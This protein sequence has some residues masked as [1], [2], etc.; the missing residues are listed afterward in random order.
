MRQVVE[1][2]HNPVRI[3]FKKRKVIL[4]SLDDLFQADLINMTEYFK[5]NR[6]FKYILMVINC[7]S[8]Y[9]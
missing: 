1:E 2:V 7:F 8:I 4:K 5:V 9:L 3:N 6:G